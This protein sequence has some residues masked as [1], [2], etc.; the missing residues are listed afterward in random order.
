MT[1]QAR[2]GERPG[3]SRNEWRRDLHRGQA[4]LSRSHAL[5]S[6]IRRHIRL[7]SSAFVYS[8]W[9]EKRLRNLRSYLC[10]KEC[11]LSARVAPLHFLALLRELDFSIPTCQQPNDAEATRSILSFPMAMLKSCRRLPRSSLS[12]STSRQ[13]RLQRTP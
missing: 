3:Y 4:G 6:G 7:I 8:V 11:S 13:G 9:S 2:S 5:L 10:S 1:L 12:S